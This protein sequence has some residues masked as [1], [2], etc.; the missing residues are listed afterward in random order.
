MTPSIRRALAAVSV[1]AFS[2]AA[3]SISSAVPALAAPSPATAL[4]GAYSNGANHLSWTDTSTTETGFAVERCYGAGCTQF[5]R[6]ATLAP[7]VTTYDDPFVAGG[8][9]TRYRVRALD[10]TGASDPSNIAEVFVLSAGEIFARITP[11]ATAGSAPLT[12]TLDA[13]ASS[14]LNGTV[15]AWDWSFGDGTT[16]SG[17]VVTHTWTTPGAWAATVKV[18]VTGVFA[19]TTSSTAVVID[20]TRPPLSA[21]AN[22]SATS[23][24]KRQV[25]LAW[26]P[27][28]SATSV[29]VQRC[30]GAACTVFSTIATVSPTATSYLD[31][32]VS[33]GVTYRYR[34]LASDGVSTAASSIAGVRVR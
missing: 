7:S 22:L 12:V 24:R 10:A 15:T 32:S 4:T 34:L 3:F 23:P 33:S 11:G 25:R 29:A 5:G 21:P 27:P 17:P 28:T 1:T 13:S 8:T 18:T 31:T 2:V 6:V 20:V 19:P 26:T 9:T 14:A 30:R 16:A